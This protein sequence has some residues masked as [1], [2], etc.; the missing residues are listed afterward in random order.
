M[1]R[2]RS[3]PCPTPSKRAFDDVESARNAYDE[4]GRQF[5]HRAHLADHAYRCMCGRWHRT[6]HDGPG[7]V[8]L[9]APGG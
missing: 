9:D 8:E 2:R 5:R 4:E 7:S 3:T 1:S 6:T